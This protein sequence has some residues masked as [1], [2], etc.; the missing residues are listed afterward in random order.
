MVTLVNRA[1]VSTAT[2]GTGILTLGSAES[3]YQTFAAAGVV[4]GD[5]VRYVVEEG[6][7]WEIGTGT[8]SADTLTRVLDES[9]TGSLLNLSGNAVVYATATGQDIV[10]P[11]DL[12]TVATTGDY[13][14]L[15]GIPVVPVMSITWDYLV[16]NWSVEPTLNATVA[17]GDVYNYT[18]GDV[19]RYRIVPEPYDATEDHFYSDFNGT[20]LSGFIVARGS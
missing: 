1:K 4:D 2:T 11:S 10:Q 6:T 8:Y 5:I 19:T 12:A 16:Q 17:S 9:S 7:S 3:G 15:T 14:D 20:A 18:Q 13:S